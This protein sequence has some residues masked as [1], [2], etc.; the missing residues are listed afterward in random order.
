[1]LLT[2]NADVAKKK[3]NFPVMLNSHASL[4]AIRWEIAVSINATKSAVME[5]AR[6]VNRFA[7]S[8]WHAKTTNV[9]GI[10]N[11]KQVLID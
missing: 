2:K 3:R 9:K 1:M 10:F 7:I 11:L 5:I 4:N 6:L 8:Y